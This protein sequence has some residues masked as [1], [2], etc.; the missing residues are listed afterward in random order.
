[1]QQLIYDIVINA[2]FSLLLIKPYVTKVI[3]VW[4]F[5]LEKKV[6]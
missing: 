3:S 5:N 4:F 2:E 1:M 6:F